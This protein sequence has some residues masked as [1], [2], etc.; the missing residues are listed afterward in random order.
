MPHPSPSTPVVSA[1]PR[2][3]PWWV[4]TLLLVVCI[5]VA[6]L[7]LHNAIELADLA[8]ADWVRGLIDA[9]ALALM[10]GP[11]FGWLMYRRHVD[12]RIALE[13]RDRLTRVPNS[14]HKR[15][16]IAVFGSMAMIA[17]IVAASLWGNVATT[18][19]MAHS[20]EVV[21]LAGRQ[22]M[23][24]ERVARFSYGAITNPVAAD[25]MRAAAR[26]MQADAHTIE[27]VT[28]SFD[29][30]TFAAAQRAR[31]AFI[32]SGTTRDSLVAATV[33]MTQFVVGSERRRLAAVEVERQAE[34]MRVKAEVTVMA[35]QRYSEERVRRSVQLSWLVAVMV[36]VLIALIALIAI[37]PVVRQI[38]HQHQIAAARSVE[39]Q[40]LAMVAERTSNAVVI[41]DAERR[42]TWVNGGFTRLTGYSLE[43]VLGRNPGELLQCANTDPATVEALRNALRVGTSA[44]CEILNRGKDG[45][46]YWLDL[47][48]EP[49]HDRGHLAGFIAI[50]A[51]ITEQ[52]RT[53][54]ALEMQSQIASTAYLELHRAT[55]LLEEAQAVARLGSWSVDLGTGQI[56]WTREIYLLHGRDPRA[57]VPSYAEILTDV[58][59]ADAVRLDE[60][61]QQ[62]SSAGA[63]YTMVLRTARGANGVRYVRAEGRAI[64]DNAGTVIRLFGTTMDVTAAIER[65]EA[66]LQAQERAEAASQSKSE[67]LANMSHEI[68]TPLTAILGYTDLL[69]DEAIRQGA[70]DEQLQSMGTIRR[71]GEH[72]LA[73]LNDILDLS[74]IEAGRMAIERIETDLP[75]V[76]FDVDSLMRSRAAQK[77]VQLQTRLLTPIPERVF[78]DPTRLRQ[79]LMNLVGNA[80]KFTSHG[81]IDIQVELTTLDGAPAVRIAVVDTGPGMTPEQATTLFQPFVQADTSVTRRHGGSGLGL[82]IC[83]RLAS[84]M[85]GEVQLVQT[86]PGEGSTFALTLPLQAVNGARD[87]TDLQACVN[88]PSAL[89]E[90]GVYAVAL[91][92]RILLAEDGEDNQRLISHHLRKAGAYV[93]VAE[94]GRRALELIL[95]ADARGAPFGLLVTDMQ[96]PE[97]DGYTLARTLRAQQHPIPIVALTAHAMADDRQRCLDAGCDDYA[98]KPVDRGALIATCARWMQMTTK[99]PAADVVIDLFPQTT[100]YSELHDDPDFAELV[101]AFTAGL[102]AKI[103]RLEHAYTSGELR[104]LDRL[105]HQLKGAAGGY[106]YPSISSAARDVEQHA[107]TR[108]TANGTFDSGIDLAQAVTQLLAQCRLAVR[109]LEHAS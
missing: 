6:E 80:A 78:S 5:A 46:E 25:S 35:L 59:P 79:I 18:S 90:T 34:S 74:K 27:A 44:R 107:K 12:S 1:P 81:L 106:G 57:G 63:P 30:T 16:R 71:A 88:T 98:S 13:R 87:V 26:R 17:A 65:E 85:G 7:F 3:K 70:P 11:L 33:A 96:M 41:T 76:L 82:T 77:G 43:E 32:A 56:E 4:D 53:R 91:H 68:R 19:H 40:R 54:E 36:Q 72:L 99:D 84:L 60:A 2:Q 102:P 66:L 37:E 28:A 67:F 48:I 14:P 105:A 95:E 64:R 75:R 49:L 101:V 31:E 20:A 109:T 73:V 21:N 15:V 10:I 45:A 61:V 55:Q 62:A 52:V 39:F 51:E 50:K 94:H 89:K 86:T 38:K 97:M 92:G 24:T 104:E 47:S 69:R 83:R 108:V 100:L 29:V 22:R 23:L 93:V 103:A 8:V 42:V 9:A 58:I